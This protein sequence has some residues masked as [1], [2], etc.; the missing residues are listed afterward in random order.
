M[1]EITRLERARPAP[2]TAP[3]PAAWG[4]RQGLV[5]L[6]VVITVLAAGAAVALL[7]GRPVAPASEQSPESI[8]RQTDAL[9]PLRAWQIWR[10]VREGGLAVREQLQAQ[11][12]IQ[13]QQARTVWWWQMGGVLLVGA[14]GIAL[15]V[16]PLATRPA[17]AARRSRP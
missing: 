7:L 5:L 9:S 2:G 8:R 17:P 12:Q 6:G 1:R 10:S 16:L 15:I 3:R 13:Y 11:K 4:F 14:G